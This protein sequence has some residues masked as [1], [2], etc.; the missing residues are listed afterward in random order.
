[1]K[2]LNILWLAMG[3]LA[4]FLVPLTLPKPA[5]AQTATDCSKVT[6]IPQA[7]CQALIDLYTSTDGPNWTN[8]AGWNTNN[9]PCSWNGVTCIAGHVYQLYLS[10]NQMSG[11]LP[12]TLTNLT[13]WAFYVND[14]PNLCEPA[15]TAFQTWFS[16]AISEGHTGTCTSTPTATATNTPTN[17]ATKTA[18]ATATPIPSLALSSANKIVFVSTRDGNGEIYTMNADGTNLTR[19]TNNSAG[20]GS[21]VWSPDGT[22]IAFVST[23]DAGNGEIYVM[24]AD[25]TKPTRLTTDAGYDTDPSWSPDGRKL[26]FQSNPDGNNEI[27]VINV[28]GTGQTNLTNKA[29]ADIS[30]MW[31]PDGSKIAFASRRNVGGGYEIYVMNADG[32][33]PTRLTNT[34]Q[35]EGAPAWSPDSQKLV[36]QSWRDGNGELYVMNADGTNP[37]RLTTNPANDNEPSWSADGKYILF[38][39]NRDGN[40]EIYVMNA[41]GSSPTNLTKDAGWDATAVWQPVV[42]VIPTFTPTATNTATATNTPIDT[43]TATNTP[44]NTATNTPTNTPT[45]TSGFQPIDGGGGL[46]RFI[47]GDPPATWGSDHKPFCFGQP[48]VVNSSSNKYQMDGPNSVLNY[49]GTLDITGTTCLNVRN[50]FKSLGVYISG[51]QDPSAVLHQQVRMRIQH[52]FEDSSIRSA[53]L[54]ALMPLLKGEFITITLEGNSV[55]VTNWSPIIKTVAMKLAFEASEYNASEYNFNPID[56]SPYSQVV[57]NVSDWTRLAEAVVITNT[58]TPTETATNTPIDTATNTPTNTPTPKIYQCGFLPS[59]HGYNFGNFGKNSSDIGLNNWAFFKKVF[60]GSPNDGSEYDEFELEGGA[61]RTVT[62]NYFKNIYQYVDLFG[63]CHGFTLASLIR[64]SSWSGNSETIEPSVLGSYQNVKPAHAMPNEVEVRDY[65]R[66]YQAR[67]LGW[68]YDLWE[69]LQVKVR[70][71]NTYI[72]IKTALSNCSTSEPLAVWIQN[73][74]P[75]GGGHTML[76]YKVVEEGPTGKI[77]VYDSNYPNQEDRFITVSLQNQGSL[78]R[79][80]WSYELEPGEIWGDPTGYSGLRAP[81]LSLAFAP[82]LPAAAIQGGGDE[83]KNHHGKNHHGYLLSGVGSSVDLLNKDAQL[84]A[85]GKQDGQIFSNIPDAAYLPISGYNLNSSNAEVLEQY[86]VPAGEYRVEAQA[87]ATAPYDFAAYGDGAAINLKGLTSAISQVNVIT[88]SIGLAK[89]QFQPATAQGHYC[90]VRAADLNDQSGRTIELCANAPA[91]GL[92]SFEVITPTGEINYRN[93]GG[94]TT[95]TLKVEQVGA[96]P[97]VYTKTGTVAKDEL[98]SVTEQELL[99]APQAKARVSSPAAATCPN[100]VTELTVKGISGSSVFSATVPT[101]ATIQIGGAGF[102]LNPPSS[103]TLTLSNGQKVE[104]KPTKV[105]STAS[106]ISPPGEMG[107]VFQQVKVQSGLITGQINEADPTKHTGETFVIAAPKDAAGMTS[108]GYVPTLQYAWGG[109]NGRYSIGPATLVLT[110]PAA[111]VNSTTLKVKVAVMDKN[112]QTAI[113]RR[114]ALVKAEAGGV[115][116]EQT[117]TKPDSPNANLVELTLEN[118]PAGTQNVKVTLESPRNTGPQMNTDGAGDSVFLLG[119][120]AEHECQTVGS[121][122]QTVVAPIETA[123]ATPEPTAT[124]TAATSTPRPTVNATITPTIQPTVVEASVTPTAEETPVVA[125]VA[126]PTF[127]P[128]VEV[129]ATARPTYLPTEESVSQPKVVTEIPSPEATVTAM[130]TVTSSPEPS[131][132]RESEKP[133]AEPTVVAPAIT[134]PTVAVGEKPSEVPTLVPT[135]I[136]EP[137]VAATVTPI[138]ALGETTTEIKVDK[139]G[140]LTTADQK[141]KID[142]PGSAVAKDV[143]L[144]HTTTDKPHFVLTAG[145]KSI[146]SF[147]LEATDKEGTRVRKFQ[148]EYT[149]TLRYTSADLAAAGISDATTLTLTFWDEAKEEWVPVTSKVDQATQQVVCTLDHFTEFALMGDAATVNTKQQVFLPLIQK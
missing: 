51:T 3:T 88:V 112:V 45:E 116:T 50:D 54:V 115:I 96:D 76:P 77:Y 53:E 118:V 128:T 56:V 79:G 64:W 42:P 120:V 135:A 99:S 129:A 60:A 44:T 109:D 6:E 27:Y 18:T 85:L 59:E 106:F 57:F 48:P 2:R 146:Q 5:N 19:L 11:V 134:E 111:L 30:P 98:L 144:K 32:S 52:T 47:Y 82:S 49:E 92:A 121:S 100:T 131:T 12:S 127:E 4:L 103:V 75:S 89:V 139:G 91:N 113:D 37:T 136:T 15:D 65:I 132:P 126:T 117:L 35:S 110:L 101:L 40:D 38:Q 78:K 87:V 70:P 39:T 145:K 90:F 14:N 93:A 33:N 81:P 25:G 143:T 20:D 13:L 28:E 147:S 86:T 26:V 97:F 22:K 67:Q 34:A 119:A 61:H 9:T 72:A 66:L 23:R 84:N 46:T 68:E 29:E 69:N 7:E 107:Y 1:M 104:V 149:I 142:F 122:D 124:A 108:S 137:T 114:I 43:A 36:F 21:P 55:T 71:L 95:Y 16:S 83:G 102:H 10:S 62:D 133:K 73:F 17:T 123:T 125:D 63:N 8:K 148:K 74:K 31:S 58:P 94:E 105:L 130:A 141:L 138:S 140:S 24:N 80:A 41:D